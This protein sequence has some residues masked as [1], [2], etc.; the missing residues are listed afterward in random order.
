MTPLWMRIAAAV[1]VGAAL[2]LL[3]L[4]PGLMVYFVIIPLV[5]GLAFTYGIEYKRGIICNRMRLH[6][7]EADTLALLVGFVAE[8]IAF[9]YAIINQTYLGGFWG[10]TLLVMFGFLLTTAYLIK[11]YLY[12][13]PPFPITLFTAYGLFI[14][15]TLAPLYLIH[16]GAPQLL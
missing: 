16:I 13:E 14:F 1:E 12:Q 2:Y 6:C 8:V 9:D 7:K 5:A 4:Y 11:T 10:T 3:L 15:L